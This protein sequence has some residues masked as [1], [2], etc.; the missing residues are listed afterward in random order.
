MQ[1]INQNNCVKFYLQGSLKQQ[2]KNV[3]IPPVE[4]CGEL[5]KRAGSSSL[6]MA[7]AVVVEDT[8]REVRVE[9]G[10]SVNSRSCQGLAASC[11]CSL[12]SANKNLIF[13]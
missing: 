6:I 4:P 5:T 7:L 9:L 13:N 1:E 2:F 11:S 10:A 3:F 8:N 12:A